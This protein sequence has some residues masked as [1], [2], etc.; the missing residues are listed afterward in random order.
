MECSD[1]VG[2]RDLVD[3]L[4][5]TKA[6]SIYRRGDVTQYGSLDG[7]STSVPEA[8]MLEC[9]PSCSVGG[10]YVPELGLWSNYW[11]AL[12]REMVVP[13]ACLV[14]WIDDLLNA[15]LLD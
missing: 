6:E 15:I 8:G 14:Y 5:S 7:S 1:H 4:P 9:M 10:C 13:R 12:Q 2:R 11:N 3:V